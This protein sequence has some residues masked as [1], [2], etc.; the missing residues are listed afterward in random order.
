MSSEYDWLLGSHGKAGDAQS[1][2]ALAKK[3][4]RNGNAHLAAAAYDRAFG[5][6]PDSEEISRAR[7][8]LL[9]RLAVVDSGIKFRYI[10]AG[11]FLMGSDTGDPDERPV[12]P[13]QLSKYWISE[14][15]ISWATYCDL[16][17]WGPP[18][19]GAPRAGAEVI[20]D[21][22]VQ[23]AF[24]LDQENR[25]RLQYCESATTRAGDWHAHLPSGESLESPLSALF[26]PVPRDDPRRPWQYDRKPMVSVSWLEAEELCE[27]LST[28]DVL[29]RLP[30]EAEWE[31]AAR[32]GLIGCKY[33][34]GDKP[35]TGDRC[36]FDR[37]DE[38]SILPMRRFLPNGYGLYAMSGC[39]WEWTSDWYDVQYYAEAGETDPKGPSAGREKV[40]RG[41]SWADCVETVTVSFRMSR[42]ANSWRQGNWGG[43]FAPNIG[44]RICRVELNSNE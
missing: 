7:S 16:M 5:L 25:I 33:P 31:R 39:V 19:S 44:F 6:Q 3:L 13:V 15:P 4:E 8:E 9:D 32:G 42:L 30:T 10:P 43:H 23:P 24:F 27:K 12:H 14:T 36:D 22:N 41:G 20:K 1:L 28:R 37:F 17:E 35:P 2:V 38:F 21:E 34:W 26:G 29:Y 11:S 40:L 18:P